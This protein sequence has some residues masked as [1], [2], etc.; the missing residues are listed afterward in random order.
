MNRFGII[1][2]IIIPK[3]FF[4]KRL[5]L[6]NIVRKILFMDENRQN[7]RYQEIGRVVCP[8]I[9]AL[10]GILDDISSTG[11]KIHFPFSVVVDLE[12]EYMMKITLS[13]SPDEAPLQLMCKP[14]WVTENNGI[15]Q[16]GFAI[17]FSP[18]ESRLHD[19]ISFLE[20]VN[21]D[22]KPDII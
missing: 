17:L 6:I 18:D 14:M 5:L 8:E 22:D 2:L 19:F 13:R 7:T 9:C 12:R 11:C 10:T 21:E 3:R 4:I 20:Q 15:T 16:I 1:T